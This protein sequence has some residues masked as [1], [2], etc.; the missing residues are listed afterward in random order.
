MLIYVDMEYN[1]LMLVGL[2]VLYFLVMKIV[3]RR[4]QRQKPF[5]D[6]EYLS[7]LALI[8]ECS[9][10]DI[11]REAGSDW[12]LK[13]NK[14]EKDFNAYLLKGGIPHYVRDFIRRNIDDEELKK[15]YK[16]SPAGNLPRSWSE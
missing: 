11:F 5:S 2:A 3:D 9:A 8:K 16:I 13:E 10:Y 14:I 7:G 1:V 15:H 12:N 6:E 4:V